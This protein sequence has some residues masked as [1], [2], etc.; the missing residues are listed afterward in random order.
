MVRAQCD[1]GRLVDCRRSSLGLLQ[2][3]Q[4]RNDALL[5]LIAATEI[6]VIGTA[7]GVADVFF[8]QV[9]SF[10]KFPQHESLLGGVGIEQHHSI[11]VA[12]SH[13][14]NVIGLLNQIGSHHPASLA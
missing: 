7:N 5:D 3:A 11:N 14:E 8:K 4:Q 6:D 12:V 9:E 2:K 13:A 1:H 10:I